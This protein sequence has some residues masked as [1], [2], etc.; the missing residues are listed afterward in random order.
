LHIG[1]AK[2]MNL[3][4]GYAK[5]MGGVCYLR[6]DDTNPEKESQEYIDSIID[7]HKTHKYYTTIIF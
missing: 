4:F 5:K 6:F 2:A 7:V 1:H 3:N